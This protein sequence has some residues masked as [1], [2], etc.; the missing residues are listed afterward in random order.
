LKSCDCHIAVH[1]QQL[2]KLKGLIIN[3]DTPL[4]AKVDGE[5]YP[6][7]KM[8]HSHGTQYIIAVQ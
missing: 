3:T 5:K 4:R 2:L 8:A 1:H 7:G 6:D